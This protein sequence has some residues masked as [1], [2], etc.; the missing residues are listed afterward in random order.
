MNGLMSIY[1]RLRTNERGIT[2]V[3][4]AV[5]AAMVGTAIMAL[6]SDFTSALSNA[7]TAIFTPS[8]P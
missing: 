1:L 3:E 5:L 6:S 7:F 4:Y 8:A 2:A